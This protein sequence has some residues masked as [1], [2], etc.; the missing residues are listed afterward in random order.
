M[1]GTTKYPAAPSP[2]VGPAARGVIKHRERAPRPGPA[3]RALIPGKVAVGEGPAGPPQ[4]A[5]FFDRPGRRAGGGIGTGRAGVL[6]STGR[7]ARDS[8][9]NLTSSSGRSADQ[10]RI[11]LE[12]GSNTVGLVHEQVGRDRPERGAAGPG[13][14]NQLVQPAL[15]HLGKSFRDAAG[16][17]IV[18]V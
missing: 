1:L 8:E 4:A 6:R 13:I 3:V 12:T 16:P 17:G 11:C 18:I 5:P 15:P 9:I 14:V 2:D 10:G 7:P